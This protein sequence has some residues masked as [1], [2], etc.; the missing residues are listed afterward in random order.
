MTGATVHAYLGIDISKDKFDVCLLTRE[1]AYQREFDNCPSGFENLRKFLGRFTSDPLHACMEATGRYGESLSE[2]LYQT[3]C[4]VSVVN[5]ARIKSYGASKLRRNK[6]DKADSA[7]IAQYCQ[8]EDPSL[9]S[10]APESFTGLQ[11]LT[12]RLDDLQGILLM[13]QN[14]L[15]SGEKNREVIE[16]LE[17][18]LKVLAE[19][20]EETKEA[21]QSHIE[22]HPNLKRDQEL[23]VTIPGIGKL[24]AAKILGEVRDIR[25]F[26]SARQLAAYAG[27]TPRNCFSG[28]SVHK[29]ARMSK[30]GNVNLRKSVYMSAISAKKYNPIISAF[31][32][33]LLSRGLPKMAAIGA[34]MRKLL[35]LV[36]GI[37]KSGKP[38]DPDFLKN[39]EIAS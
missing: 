30:T 27:L 12:R 26:T 35:H 39:Q 8:R 32:Q 9:W 13:E 21:I 37:L 18:H 16:S 7:L 31:Y 34:A 6:T 25:D 14:R 33:R 11:S 17:A 24:T 4:K 20:I 38:F 1:K 15:K 22:K 2:F 29:K 19:M 3:G 23:L 10:P 28:T 5:P 36:F